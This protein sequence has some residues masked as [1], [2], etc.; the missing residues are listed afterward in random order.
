MIAICFYSRGQVCTR[1]CP[2]LRIHGIL[3]A[4][5]MTVHGV[6]YSFPAPW[7][8]ICLLFIAAPC[9]TQGYDAVE[10][11]WAL[12]GAEEAALAMLRRLQ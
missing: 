9:C 12:H 1:R 7:V 10:H 4:A 2:K 8:V 3:Q 6:T 5:A 11:E